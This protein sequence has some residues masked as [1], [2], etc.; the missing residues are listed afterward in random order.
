MGQGT[1]STTYITK[2]LFEGIYRE[3]QPMIILTLV[4]RC[5]ITHQECIAFNT[6]H[7]GLG[8]T[9]QNSV[10]FLTFL[11]FQRLFHELMSQ[12][13]ACLYLSECIFH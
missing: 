9:E 5:F 3:G 1:L 11:K 7:T 6:Y 4:R 2:Q 12:Y 8:F 10:C 13:Q